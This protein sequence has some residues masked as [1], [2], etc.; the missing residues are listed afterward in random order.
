MKDESGNSVSSAAQFQRELLSMG[1]TL[2]RLEQQLDR[3]W[4]SG[5]RINT[6]KF[7]TRQ[8]R[9]GTVMLIAKADTAEGKI[10]SFHDGTSV[11]EALKGFTARLTNGQVKWKPDAYA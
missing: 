6:L 5:I 2:L 3:Y 11:G 7:S 9:G 8:S 4:E 1:E 10:V